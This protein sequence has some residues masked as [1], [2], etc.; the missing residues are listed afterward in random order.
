MPEKKRFLRLRRVIIIV[1]NLHLYVARP[2]VVKQHIV[3]HCHAL[4]ISSNYLR[5][6]LLLLY[7]YHCLQLGLI[8]LPPTGALCPGGGL[9]VWVPSVRPSVRPSVCLSVRPSVRPSVCPSVTTDFSHMRSSF[10][11]IFYTRH[12]H[13]MGQMHTKPLLCPAKNGEISA[14]FLKFWGSTFFRDNPF[15][16]HA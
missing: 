10:T 9:M 3:F 14:I 16:P 4:V 7:L 5:L 6:K 12:T 8:F 15:L 2:S 1:V 11:L 13:G